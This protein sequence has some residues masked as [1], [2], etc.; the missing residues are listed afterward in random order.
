MT[1][2]DVDRSWIESQLES[3]QWRTS[4]YS[5]GGTNCVQVAYLDEGIVALRD[6]KDTNRPPL[7]FTGSECQAF[8]DGIAR[9]LLRRR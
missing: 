4:S 5:S 9:D 1:P 8:I 3:A 2:N 7:L 6:S